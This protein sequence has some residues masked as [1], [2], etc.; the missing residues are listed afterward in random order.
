MTARDLPNTGIAII[1]DIGEEGDIHPKNK[2]DVGLRLA[3]AALSQTYGEK[4][5]AAARL[6]SAQHQ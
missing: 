2:Q 3:L 4:I 5:E 6:C 1:T